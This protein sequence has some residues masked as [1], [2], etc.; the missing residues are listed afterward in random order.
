[1]H[2]EEIGTAIVDCAVHVHHDLGPEL[3][4]TLYEVTLARQIEKR[5]PSEGCDSSSVP[6]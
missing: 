3:V 1:M 5:G 2:Q 6:P 4:E